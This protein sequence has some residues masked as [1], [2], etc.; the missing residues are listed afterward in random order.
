MSKSKFKDFYDIIKENLESYDEKYDDFINYGPELF[1]LLIETLNDKKM[2]SKLRLEVSAALAYYVA[3]FDIIPETIYGPYGYIDDIF[4][5]LYV[6]RDI[7]RE[8]GYKFL[9]DL[10]ENERNLNE[11]MDECYS[12][13]KA[14]VDDKIDYMLEYVGLKE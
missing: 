1:K 14:I 9:E 13:S 2:K 11:V 7:E 4:I 12:K 3:P 10:W 5:C 8:L 6:L